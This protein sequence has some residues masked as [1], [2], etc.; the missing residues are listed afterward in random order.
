M[1]SISFQKAEFQAADV[2]PSG[3]NVI[4]SGQVSEGLAT[5]PSSRHSF[6]V[7]THVL[8]HQNPVRETQHML[9]HCVAL[10]IHDEDIK[11]RLNHEYRACFIS[12]RRHCVKEL[13][14][15]LVLTYFDPDN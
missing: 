15:Y 4:W 5:R 12:L 11:C 6:L 1:T 10:F 2:K 13:L 8:E 7:L 9:V 3:V 14:I